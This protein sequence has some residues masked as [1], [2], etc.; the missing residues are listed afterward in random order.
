MAKYRKKVFLFKAEALA[1]SGQLDEAVRFAENAISNGH[2]DEA[3]ILVKF[4][5]WSSHATICDETGNIYN[6]FQ[7]FNELKQKVALALFK[8]EEFEKFYELAVSSELDP[9]TVMSTRFLSRISFVIL[10][11]LF[12]CFCSMFPFCFP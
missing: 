5:K 11:I 6:Y 2:Y 10:D 3:E 7:K 1:D 9:R 12:L 8:R 4:N